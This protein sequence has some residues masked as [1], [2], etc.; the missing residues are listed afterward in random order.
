MFRR[1]FHFCLYCAFMVSVNGLLGGCDSR[2]EWQEGAYQLRWIDTPELFLVYT[3]DQGQNM[4]LIEADVIGIGSDQTHI[5][6]RQRHHQSREIS[7]FLINKQAAN[8]RNTSHAENMQRL[9]EKEYL[10]QSAHTS[11]PNISREFHYA[12]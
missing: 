5:I 4:T 2:N 7:Y 3:N 9:S 12:E 10:S 1:S 8:M 11:W 6:V